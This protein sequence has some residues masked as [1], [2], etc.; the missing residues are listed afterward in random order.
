MVRGVPSIAHARGTVQCEAAAASTRSTMTSETETLRKKTLPL[1]RAVFTAKGRVGLP[2]HT[3][4]REYEE[5]CME[6]LKFRE[7][8]YGSL[9]QFLRDNPEICTLTR[10]REGFLVVKGIATEEDKHVF[11]LVS[12]QRP[13]RKK[14]RSS[15]PKRLQISQISRRSASDFSKRIYNNPQT[16]RPTLSGNSYSLLFRQSSGT[17]R[18][19]NGVTATF[20]SN[21]NSGTGR[22]NQVAHK[23]MRQGGYNINNSYNNNLPP[24]LQ[25]QQ[26]NIQSQYNR[27]SVASGNTKHDAIVIPDENIHQNKRT[28][29]NFSLPSG[30]RIVVGPSSTSTP[31]AN[32]TTTLSPSG[33]NVY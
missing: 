23:P 22:T 19:F 7:M 13:E 24:R 17:P 32:T 33:K 27:S 1:L 5:T 28:F 10:G 26:F 8:G 6:T 25:K 18:C 15:V 29:G 9:E 21:R 12:G 11:N 16:F 14:K 2:L 3:L 4:C 30:E 20:N 31:N